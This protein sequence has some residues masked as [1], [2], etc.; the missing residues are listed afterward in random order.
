MEHASVIK[1][2]SH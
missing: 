2:D 1:A